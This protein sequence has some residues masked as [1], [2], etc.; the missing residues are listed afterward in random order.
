MT[1]DWHSIQCE[2]GRSRLP[3]A[4]KE[5]ISG[6]GNDEISAPASRNRVNQNR[7]VQVALMICREYHWHGVV[8]VLQSAE[9]I[10]AAYTWTRK[11]PDGKSKGAIHNK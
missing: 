4:I 5:I 11:N 8:T 10:K 3:T 9:A 1:I 7:G 2:R 6:C